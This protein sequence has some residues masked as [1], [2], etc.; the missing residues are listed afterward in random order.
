[1]GR[2]DNGLN[3]FPKTRLAFW[4]WAHDAAAW[5]ENWIHDNRILPAADKALREATYYGQ[6]YY[7]QNPQ[8]LS[9]GYYNSRTGARSE[10]SPYWHGQK[11]FAVFDPD[12][13][14][15]PWV[16]E[17][18]VVQEEANCPKRSG[19][20]VG[21]TEGMS[22]RLLSSPQISSLEKPPPSKSESS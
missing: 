2:N 10:P 22:G 18:D 9:Y 15:W 7:G 21:K 12:G 14:A 6:D 8:I 20:P 1:M 3:L 13:A 17:A 5:L 16:N 11:P 4:E 19:L